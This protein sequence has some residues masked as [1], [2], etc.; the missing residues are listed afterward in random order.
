MSHLYLCKR[1]KVDKRDYR[2]EKMI[3][4]KPTISLPKSYRIKNEY[5]P[6]ILDQGDLGSCTANAV[7]NAV[8]SIIIKENRPIFQPSRLYIYWFSR[9]I[10]NTISSDSGVSLRDTM[11]AIKKNGACDEQIWQYIISNYTIKPPTNAIDNGISNKKNFVYL[12]VGQNL[13]SIKNAI[14]QDFPIVFVIDVYSSFESDKV[15][16][17]GVVPMPKV[18]TEQLLGGHAI[19]MIS[20]DDTKKVFGCMNSWGT[21]WGDKGFFTLPYTY[22][23]NT[24]LA[25]DFWTIHF[26]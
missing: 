13:N 9:E 21:S 24:Q 4:F 8:K 23:L 12:S 20:Y 19:M 14:S 2:F 7:S 6:G 11:N 5:I 18:N 16:K 3:S 26:F 22:V 1:Q 15:S 17:N 25:F 10:E